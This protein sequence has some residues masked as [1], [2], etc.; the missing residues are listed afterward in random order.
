MLEPG[1]FQ[2]DIQHLKKNPQSLAPVFEYLQRKIERNHRQLLEHDPHFPEFSL[3]NPRIDAEL[4][5]EPQ[6]GQTLINLIIAQVKQGLTFQGGAPALYR[7]ILW[8]L[9]DLA[10]ALVEQCDMSTYWQRSGTTALHVAAMCR[11]PAVV[12]ALLN[13]G[14]Q[15]ST[16]DDGDETAFHLVFGQPDLNH[17]CY[18]ANSHGRFAGF[19]QTRYSKQR[20]NISAQLAVV[21]ALLTAPGGQ[22]ILQL[23]NGE[24]PLFEAIYNAARVDTNYNEIRIRLLKHLDHMGVSFNVRDLRGRTPLHIAAAHTAVTL[25]HFLV[26]SDVDITQ[27]DQDGLTAMAH[28]VRSKTPQAHQALS[29]LQQA[30]IAELG[31]VLATA[32]VD[33]VKQQQLV[34]EL[35][36]SGLNFIELPKLTAALKQQAQASQEVARDLRQQGLDPTKSRGEMAISAAQI[37]LA[38]QHLRR[39]IVALRAGEFDR[40][41]QKLST[42]I[43]SLEPIFNYIRVKRQFNYAKLREAVPDLPMF[44]LHNSTIDAELFGKQGAGYELC[45]HII[46]LSR[47]GIKFQQGE[48][49]LYR[50]ILWGLDDLALDLIELCKLDN[51]WQQIGT[52]PLHLAAVCRRPKVV[53]AL[54]NKGLSATSIDNRG[55]RPLDLLMQSPTSSQVFHKRALDGYI[56]RYDAAAFNAADNN[57]AQVQVA[58]LLLNAPRGKQV[59]EPLEYQVSPIFDVLEKAMDHDNYYDETRLQFLKHLLGY[60]ASLKHQDAAGNTALHHAAAH[61]AVTVTHFLVKSE[62]DVAL[63]N[64]QGQTAMEYVA[65]QEAA[66]AKMGLRLLQQAYIAELG[67]MMLLAPD[68][69]ER[70]Q[71]F[72][73][74]LLNSGVTTKLMPQLFFELQK[75]MERFNSTAQELTAKGNNPVDSIGEI[76]ILPQHLRLAQ[77]RLMEAIYDRE[78]ASRAKIRSSAKQWAKFSWALLIPGIVALVKLF[79]LIHAKNSRTVYAVD[80]KVEQYAQCAS[81]DEKGFNKTTVGSLKQRLL[82]RMP[83]KHKKDG[84]FQ[85]QHAVVFK[86]KQDLSNAA[87]ME[88]FNG[89]SEGKARPDID[90]DLR[91]YLA[92]KKQAHQFAH[93]ETDF[94]IKVF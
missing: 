90:G 20:N 33:Q 56:D 75:E 60:G 15:V 37:E 92:G 55:L 42:Q 17:I 61:N 52:T 39:A 66:T 44:S 23:E 87:L 83:A 13:K 77:A 35:I 41:M 45:N 73:D 25:S 47:G 85:I 88:M 32:L 78:H 24:N 84:D 51:F 57:A 50:A 59:L 67:R 34:A 27:V 7:A 80:M 65:A 79:Q 64:E 62:V 63:K 46:N 86:P 28:L 82:A 89:R 21:D 2:R 12:T 4:F 5:G 11:R 48:P 91:V 8:G 38:E 72:V 10:V 31:R 49:A 71:I 58:D 76:S 40:D 18:E 69:K 68:N 36:D 70:Q 3:S 9:D 14:F 6:A 54:L 94:A 43:T 1:E 26:Q 30:Y 16:L 22:A 29:L 74:E 81:D 93:R 53:Q 19:D